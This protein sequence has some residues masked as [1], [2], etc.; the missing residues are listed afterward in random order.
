M[1]TTPERLRHNS[2]INSLARL[3]FVPAATACVYMRMFVSMK[4]L[5]LV[6]LVSRAGRCPMEVEAL[7]EPSE[8]LPTRLIECIPL[9][10]HHF[11]PVG[12][13][14]ADG[15][16]FLRCQE[17]RLS[18]LGVNLQDDG[19][20]LCMSQPRTRKSAPATI[21]TPSMIAMNTFP[22]RRSTISLP[23]QDPN[24][25]ISPNARPANTSAPVRTAVW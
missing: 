7:A 16:T 24:T 6:K 15:A 4:Y 8:S 20:F 19:P 17:A 18:E 13:Q 23:S 12:Q 3:C 21:S 1:F 11:S 10:H 5:S 25:M 9:T 2:S 22:G 14:G